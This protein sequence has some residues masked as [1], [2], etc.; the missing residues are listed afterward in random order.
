MLATVLVAAP[1]DAQQKNL[2]VSRKV[3]AAPALDGTVDATW[4][5]APVLTVKAVGGKNFPGG[6]TEMGLRSVVAGDSIYFLVQYKD[7]TQ[8]VRRSPW[9]KQA[10]GSWAVVK[11]PDNKG[12]DNNLYYEDKFAMIWNISSP[13]FEQRGCMS[14]CHTG[15]GKPYGNK[16]LPG[17]DERADMWHLKGV[18][19]STVGQVDDQYLDGTRYDKEKAREAG[20]KSD[21]KA[22]GGYADNATEDKKA[23]KFAL[24]GNKPAPPYWILDAEKEPFDDSKYKAGDEVPGIVVSPLLGDRGDLS[25]KVSWKDGVYTVVMWRKLVTDGPYDVQ[26]SDLKKAYVFGVAAFDNAQVRHA[27]VPTALKLVFE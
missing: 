17:A 1:L 26:F 5:A 7:A 9:Q 25:A 23:P 14:A 3:A 27:Y 15:E 4:A 6:S 10:D 18:R 12:G 13:A 20:R 16:Y 22:G 8:S 21:P 11:D 19:T 2:L 24:K